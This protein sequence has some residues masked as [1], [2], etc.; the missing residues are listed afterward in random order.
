[1]TDIF[2]S[3]FIRP[4]NAAVPEKYDFVSEKS[5]AVCGDTVTFYMSFDGDTVS[6]AGYEVLGCS[7][8]IAS[9]SAVSEMIIGRETGFAERISADDISAYLG[10]IPDNRKECIITVLDS[11]RSCIYQQKH[12]QSGDQL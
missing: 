1:M 5:S 6:D 7:V 11:V 12:S 2:K 9:A 8:A 3:H 4:R 10:G